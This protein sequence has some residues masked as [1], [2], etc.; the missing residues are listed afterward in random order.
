MRL[1][2]QIAGIVALV[3]Y[4]VMGAMLYFTVIPGADGFW[5][6]DFHLRGYNAASIAGFVGALRDEARDTYA[7]ILTGWDR[8][9]I[10]SLAIWLALTGWRGGWMKYAVA[11]LAVIYAVIDLAENAAIYRFVCVYILDPATVAAASDLTMA[12]FASLYLCILVL[13][14][15]VRRTA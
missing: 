14:V 1:S 7:L 6:P 3:S 12:K 4:L 13:I 2:R 9:F 10:I 8:V 11:F 5:P 15:H